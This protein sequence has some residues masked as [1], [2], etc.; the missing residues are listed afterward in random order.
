M[1]S[2]YRFRRRPYRQRRKRTE[3]ERAAFLNGLSEKVREPMTVEELKAKYI[4]LF[5]TD[6]K[7]ERKREADSITS[8]SLPT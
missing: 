5:H 2:R 8:G 1:R 7:A 3:E 4:A 6:M